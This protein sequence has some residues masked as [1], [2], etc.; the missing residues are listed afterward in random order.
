MDRKHVISGSLWL[1]VSLFVAFMAVDLGLGTLTQPGS[2]FIFFCSSVG[3][4]VLSVILI[5]KS[6]LR[7]GEATPLMD[8]WKG[9]KWGNAVLAIGILFFYALILDELGFILSTFLLMTVLFGLGRSR[10]W[11]VI[12][13]AV[14]TTILSFVIFGYFLGVRLPKGILGS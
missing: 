4:G 7:K 8:G 1:A 10:Y 5:I 13:S 11:V 12:A 9:L 14:M 3:L 6:V 2:G